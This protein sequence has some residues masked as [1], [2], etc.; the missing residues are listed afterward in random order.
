[1]NIDEAESFAFQ[2]ETVHPCVEHP[3]YVIN[4]SKTKQDEPVD[5]SGYLIMI[6][7]NGDTIAGCSPG[8]AWIMYPATITGTHPD[9]AKHPHAIR[10]P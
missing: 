4:G 7:S 6:N 5:F 8:S 1:M 2:Q 3:I 10:L 9:I